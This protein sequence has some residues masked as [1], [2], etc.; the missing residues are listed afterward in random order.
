VPLSSRPW[1]IFPHHFFF[2][3]TEVK[4][5]IFLPFLIE[6]LKGRRDQSFS[7]RSVV[8]AN[9]AQGVFFSSWQMRAFRRL[10]PFLGVCQGGKILFFLRYGREVPRFPLY[11]KGSGARRF[12]LSLLCGLTRWAEVSVFFSFHHQPGDVPFSLFDLDRHSGL[13][14]SSFASRTDARP[15]ISL[16]R[17]FPLHPPPFRPPGG[18]LLRGTFFRFLV[19]PSPCVSVPAVL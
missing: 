12:P 1:R 2:I 9:C 17:F 8:I 3:S 16:K 19:G 4:G 13:P 18:N 15:E 6:S 5:L 7:S 14:L 11:F 10:P